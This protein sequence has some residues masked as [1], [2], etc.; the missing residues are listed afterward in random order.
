[1]RFKGLS[2]RQWFRLFGVFVLPTLIV[3][4][5]SCSSSSSEDEV[6]EPLTQLQPEQATQPAPPNSNADLT[7]RFVGTWDKVSSQGNPV[8]SRTQVLTFSEDG[9]VQ[10]SSSDG[11][12]ETN[13]TAQYSILDA[14]HIQFTFKDGTSYIANYSFSGATLTIVAKD[15]TGVFERA[16]VD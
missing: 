8:P 5:T 14:S 7:S 11:S 13:F 6:I 4:S 3:L 2:R 9:T 12:S 1:M 16:R 10:S 15:I